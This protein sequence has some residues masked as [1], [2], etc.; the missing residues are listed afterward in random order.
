MAPTTTGGWAV[1]VCWGPGL[2]GHPPRPAAPPHP[3]PQEPGPSCS[4]RP[5]ACARQNQDPR[6][7]GQ[8]MLEPNQ[9][10]FRNFYHNIGTEHIGQVKLKFFF[11]SGKG[12]RKI[13]FR[14]EIYGLS[15]QSTGDASSAENQG[16][17]IFFPLGQWFQI[18]LLP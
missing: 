13:L 14:L 16:S 6:F 2:A 17:Y 4:V 3:P 15:P 8:E 18:F 11:K 5:A 12:K 9:M 10:F 1:L 7:P